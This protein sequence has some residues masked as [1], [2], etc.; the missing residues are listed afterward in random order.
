MI[1]YSRRRFLRDVLV[2]TAASS[3]PA[4]GAGGRLRCMA[5]GQSAIQYDLRRQPYAQ[6]APIAALLKQADICI[7]DLETA[8]A[9]PDTL[10]PTNKTQFLKAA[11]PAVLDCL[12]DLSIN[13]LALSNNHSW[14]LGAAGIFST[15]EAVRAR[16]FVYAG[17][18]ANL[19]QAAAPGYRE[20]QAGRIALVAMASG[21]IRDGAAATA[22][23]AGVNEARLAADGAIDAAD[24]ARILGAISEATRSAAY[25]FCY[26]HNHYWEKDFRVTPEWQRL[27][28]RR[29]IDAGAHAFI[30]HGAPLLQGIEIYRD[31]PIF[32]DL[33]SFV[34]QSRTEVGYYPPEVWESVVADC[35]FDAGK[36]VSLELTPLMLNERGV[37]KDQFY[38][39]RGRPVIA[40]GGD[41]SRILN[42]L[43]DLSSAG[44]ATIKIKG[45]IGH[46]AI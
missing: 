25:V 37:S 8:V 32:Y 36:L 15:L 11:P 16:G 19:E 23:R 1:E 13:V 43:R 5:L 42:R 12:A 46:V 40:R 30:S 17:T 24:A 29:C 34:F 39:T 31:R 2:V 10:L 41:A 4:Y 14:D 33:G 20:T 7:T 44:G 35:V 38:E 28:A 9:E 3:L 18:G 26:Q 45:D 6:Y 22:T 21:S 27:W